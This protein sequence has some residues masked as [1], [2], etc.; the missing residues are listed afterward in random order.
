MYSFSLETLRI[1]RKVS[2]GFGTKNM[3]ARTRSG[4]TL[5]S[6]PAEVPLS[7]FVLQSPGEE[8]TSPKS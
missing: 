6:V 8:Q 2:L 4:A 1:D 5:L 3:L 7:P